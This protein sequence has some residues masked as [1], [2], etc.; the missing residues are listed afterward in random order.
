[1]SKDGQPC[2]IKNVAELSRKRKWAERW[3]GKCC[4]DGIGIVYCAE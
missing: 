4:W 1:M 3:V 2:D